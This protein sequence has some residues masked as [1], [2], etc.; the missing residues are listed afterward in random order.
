MSDHSSPSSE[1]SDNSETFDVCDLRLDNMHLEETSLGTE[2]SDVERQQIESFLSGLG[3][4]IYVSSSMANLYQAAGVKSKKDWHL[5][6]TGVPVLMYDKGSAKSRC[7]PRVTFVLAER[8][9][10]FALWKDTIDNLSSYKVSGKAF[11]T[12]C[13]STDHSRVI[14]FSFDSNEAAMEFWENVERL[15]SN[16]EN[17][18]LSAPGRKR[19]SMKN[20]R[21]KAKPLP[22]KSQISLPC[23]FAHVT[24]VTMGDA[25]RYHSLRLFVNS[26]RI[27]EEEI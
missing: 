9:T 12:M 15:T 6:Y 21:V 4:E 3:T 13:L 22:P 17:I 1:A 26:G 16:P 25:P 27:V 24:N 5:T 11:H 2:V 8:G 18:S 19:K 10:C 14:G 7:A 20:K 23:Q